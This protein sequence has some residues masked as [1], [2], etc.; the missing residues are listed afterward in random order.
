VQAAVTTY[1]NRQEQIRQEAIRQENERIEGIRLENERQENMRIAAEAA[2]RQQ[3]AQVTADIGGN[4][5]AGSTQL[6]TTLSGGAGI[7]NLASLDL[8]SVNLD[9]AFNVSNDLGGGNSRTGSSNAGLNPGS[10]PFTANLG[11]VTVD[12]SSYSL[13]ADNQEEKKK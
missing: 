5:V 8:T 9:T 13:Q 10:N 4:Q 7:V 2:L 11:Q 6:A 1:E 3:T 12:G